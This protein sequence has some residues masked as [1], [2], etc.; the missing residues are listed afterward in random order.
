M[1]TH[2]RQLEIHMNLGIVN[3]L[4]TGNTISLL[5]CT[6]YEPLT[7]QRYVFFF[8][9]YRFPNRFRKTVLK[10]SSFITSA[11]RVFEA[12][13]SLALFHQVVRNR[14]WKIDPIASSN[15][16]YELESLIA[17]TNCIYYAS[18]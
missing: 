15:I 7:T 18:N 11:G 3:A 6:P 5:P 10:I 9:N 12:G 8:R 16:V 1:L 2:R 13:S 17:I 14:I 4:N